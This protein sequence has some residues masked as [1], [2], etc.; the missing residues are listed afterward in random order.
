MLIGVLLAPVA[1]IIIISLPFSL[2]C[3]RQALLLL[4][5]GSFLIRSVDDGGEDELRPEKR[6]G[7]NVSQAEVGKSPN[8]K[9]GNVWV[10]A[11]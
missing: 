2:G 8:P 6:E 10:S 1:A 4:L 5:I 3:A 11:F 9:L 7:K